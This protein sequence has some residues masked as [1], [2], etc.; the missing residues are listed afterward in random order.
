MR[1]VRFYRF[2]PISLVLV[3]MTLAA[4]LAQAA[5]ATQPLNADEQ[6][7]LTRAMN[8][9][10]SQVAMAK[11][12]LAKSTNPRVL[13]L[14]NT[15]IQERTALSARMT[16]LLAGSNEHASQTAENSPTMDRMQAL[17]GD[18]FDKTFASTAVRSHCRMI[19]AYEAVKIS[20]TNAALIGFA[21]DAIPTLRGDLMVAMAVLRSAGWTVPHHQE[22]VASADTHG[23]SKA[24]VFW[25]P[26]SLVAA[27]W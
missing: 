14:A 4:G 23:G 18:A 26:I 8:D 2:V 17:S 10:D 20:S 11:L 22:A 6:A 21:H 1:V 16:Q 19:S 24:P 25:E 9:N 13:Q 12:A 15:I 7:F 3:W 27:P 5:D